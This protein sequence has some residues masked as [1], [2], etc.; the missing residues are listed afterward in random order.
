MAELLTRTGQSGHKKTAVNAAVFFGA[1]DRGISGVRGADYQLKATEPSGK[2]L[3]HHWQK[4]IMLF[5][6]CLMGG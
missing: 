1:A 4:S 3:C 6:K 2:G 5:L